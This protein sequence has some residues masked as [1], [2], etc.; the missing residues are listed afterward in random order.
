MQCTWIIL[1]PASPP[2]PWK[3]CLPQNLCLVPN[4]WRPLLYGCVNIYWH[5]HL[6][7]KDYV[8]KD[9]NIA[10]CVCWLRNYLKSWI[11]RC[12]AW[13]RGS[14]ASD[15][16]WRTYQLRGRFLSSYLV[17]VRL[18]QKL[19]SFQ[20]QSKIAVHWTGSIFNPAATSFLLTPCP[21]QQV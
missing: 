18:S 20:V 14:K 11:V 3:N 4:G 2:G 16:K 8:L 9:K 13:T 1:K 19:L 15:S 17:H 6:E 21:G 5:W 10:V 7:S 12:G